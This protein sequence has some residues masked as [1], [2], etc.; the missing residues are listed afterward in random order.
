[1][2]LAVGEALATK[3]PTVQL[4]AGSQGPAVCRGFLIVPQPMNG[5][6]NRAGCP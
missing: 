5:F 6:Q 2:M 3:L 1:M 4:I